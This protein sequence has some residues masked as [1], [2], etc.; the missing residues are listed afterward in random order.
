M[1]YFVCK[2]CGKF[3]DDGDVIGCVCLDC[4][5]EIYDRQTKTEHIEEKEQV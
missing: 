5:D 4:I 2:E 1:V 3:T